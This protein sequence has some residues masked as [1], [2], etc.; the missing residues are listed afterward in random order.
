MQVISYLKKP[1]LLYFVL[2]LIFL[3]G[4]VIRL[5]HFDSPIADWMSWRQADTAAVTRNFVKEG[6]TPLYPKFDAEN[7]LNAQH[8]PDPDRY[9]FAEFP[10]Y[11]ILTYEGF[12]LFGHFT[13]EEWG[14]LVTIFFS[15]LTPP[16]L[17]F[18]V[19]EYSS[20]R[21]AFFAAFIYTFLPYNIYYG[22]VILP[23]PMYVFFSVLAVFL[24]TQWIRKKKLW[25][26]IVAAIAFAFAI[27]LKPYALVLT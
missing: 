20:R 22:R 18:L 19:K 14:R 15:C 10:L 6:F 3:F 11:N 26:C 23:D 4:F 7:S 17:Y 25:L 9:F 5:Y 21:I 1:Y 12:T 8:F 16:I 27:L 13:I 2:Y 24:T